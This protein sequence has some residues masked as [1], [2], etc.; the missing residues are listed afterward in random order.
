MSF[1]EYILLFIGAY[2]IGSFPSAWLLLK[3]KSNKDIREAGSGNVGT[4]NAMRVSKSKLIGALVLI[5]D[6]S[7]GALPAWYLN[8]LSPNDGFAV[9]LLVNALLLGH[10]YPVWIKFRG[11]RGL[12]VIAGA[13]AVIEPA[14]LLIW[15]GVWIAIYIF[16]KKHIVA[17]MAATFALPLFVFFTYKFYF[18]SYILVMILPTAML[19]FQKHLER[20][21]DLVEEKR[22]KI[23]NGE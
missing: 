6:F 11:G 5:L 3:I 7:K 8:I 12:A 4:L 13:V 23:L 16:T 17:S 10:V 21:P 19:I 14:L 1:I 20:I 2:L 18:D 9:I 22:K 15:L